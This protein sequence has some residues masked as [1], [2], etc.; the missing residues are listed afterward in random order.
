MFENGDII[1]SSDLSDSFNT[2][3][4]SFIAKLDKHSNLLWFKNYLIHHWFSIY[5][6]N[7][8]FSDREFVDYA[9]LKKLY[10][11]SNVNYFNCKNDT[12]NDEPVRIENI[13]IANSN[14]KII[15]KIN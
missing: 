3:G 9:D 5:K 10:S 2:T 11:K 7:I 14:G 8:Y 4:E 15:K 6:N 1:V 12:I 13:V